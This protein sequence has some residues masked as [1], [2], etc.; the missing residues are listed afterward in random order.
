MNMNEAELWIKDSPVYENDGTLTE[1]EVLEGD[2][3]EEEE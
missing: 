2:I 3:Y 1:E